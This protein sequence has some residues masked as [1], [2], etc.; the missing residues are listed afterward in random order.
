[1]LIFRV[2]FLLSVILLPVMVVMSVFARIVPTKQNL[3]IFGSG[4]GQTYEGNAKALFRYATDKDQVQAV[5]ISRNP[6]IVN[7]IRAEGG[8]AYTLHSLAG[9]YYVLR[10]DVTFLTHGNFDVS[11]WLIGGSTIVQLWHG[12]PIKRIKNDARSESVSALDKVRDWLIPEWD[13]VVSTCDG[14]TATV[15]CS[16]LDIPRN[17]ILTLGY[18]RNDILAGNEFLATGVPNGMNPNT[19]KETVI[20][21]MPTYRRFNS[22]FEIKSV[23]TEPTL[24]ICLSEHDAKFYVSLHPYSKLPN[25]PL[26]SDRIHILD[27]DT[28]IYQ[29]MKIADILITDYSSAYI[30]F[31]L[32]GKEVMFYAPDL[33]QYIENRGFY[34]PYEDVTPGPVVDSTKTLVEELNIIL[35]K[36]STRS[37]EYESVRRMYHVHTDDNSCDR[38]YEY[39][40]MENS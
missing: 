25:E 13:Y 2:R 3:W 9:I 32:T 19:R 30:D 39:F 17:K 29:F 22:S 36:T 8:K 24:E 7:Q 34:Y 27:Q 35:D 5:W 31:L 10:G 40:I 18:P 33:A 1:M 12:N 37:P 16:A 38:V 26:Q 20:L 28:D 14:P 23:L 21:Y 15:L 4:S 6:E 11:R